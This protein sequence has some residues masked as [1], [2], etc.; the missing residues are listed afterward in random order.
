MK[1]FLIFLCIGLLGCS[2]TGK[3]V[4]SKKPVSTK[5]V[6][7]TMNFAKKP[8]KSYINKQINIDEKEVDKVISI[9]SEA[10]KNKP[11][12]GGAYYNRAIAY[13]FKKDYDKCWSDV[14]KAE[15]FGLKFDPAFIKSLKEVSG[16]TK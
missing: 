10:I 7:Q 9:F 11:N 5:P 4:K 8:E 2:A 3:T 12:Y 13:F 6:Q 1:K 14:K 16:R 15:G